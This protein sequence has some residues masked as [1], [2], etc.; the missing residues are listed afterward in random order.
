VA[1]IGQLKLRHYFEE[2]SEERTAIGTQKHSRAFIKIHRTLRMSPAMAAGVT[3][4]LWS[5][6][7]LVTPLGSL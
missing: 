5:V 2:T 4:R 6:E 3:D 7:D 1:A